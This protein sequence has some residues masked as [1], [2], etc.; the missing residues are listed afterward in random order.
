MDEAY[1]T[2]LVVR[3]QHAQQV[4]QPFNRH[5]RSD[6]DTDRVGDAPEIL[7]MCT[8]DIGRAHADP[9][10]MRGQVVPVFAVS[11][12]AR[13]RLLIG[14]VQTLVRSVNIRSLRVVQRPAGN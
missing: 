10:E 5:A 3:I 13:L 2:G 7:D 6:L 12:K 8:V 11:E 1:A 4:L 14:Q 9:G